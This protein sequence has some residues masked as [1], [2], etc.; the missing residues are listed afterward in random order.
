MVN[1]HTTRFSANKTGNIR[2]TQHW[3][4]FVQ[5]LMQWKS[6]KYYIFWVRVCSL[7]YPACNTHAPYCY[8]WPVWRYH[9]F[10][11]FLTIFEKKKVM[12]HKRCVLIFATNLSDTFLIL[13]RIRRD[14]I[15]N[16]AASPCKV[17]LFS[18]DFRETWIFST[19]FRKILQY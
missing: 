7:M 19:D 10:P 5:P 12:E 11:H 9:I 16:V 8:L 3:S 15:I 14:I 17:L 1:I 6:N 13:R 4:A 2:I 18:S